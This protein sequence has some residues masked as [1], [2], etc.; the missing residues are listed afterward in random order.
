MIQHILLFRFH[1]GTSSEAIENIMNKFLECKEKLPEFVNMQHGSNVSAKKHLSKGF[2]YGVIMTFTNQEAIA[3]YNELDEHKEA[4]ELQKPYLE[5]VLVFD[6]E[7][8][9]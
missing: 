2:T 3:K 6:I 1:E 7:E 8:S 5:E 4:Q 9:N